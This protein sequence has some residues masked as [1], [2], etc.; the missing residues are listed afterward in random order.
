MSQFFISFHNPLLNYF[1][2]FYWADMFTVMLLVL[3]AYMVITRQSKSIVKK[4]IA[5]N[6]WLYNFRTEVY[7]NFEKNFFV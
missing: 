6:K 5:Y 3:L 1:A 4:N 2:F 7:T